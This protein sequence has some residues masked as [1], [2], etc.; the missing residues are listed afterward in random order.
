MSCRGRFGQPKSMRSKPGALGPSE[1]ARLAHPA[2][3]ERRPGVHGPRGTHVNH[4]AWSGAR[5]T[6]LSPRRRSLSTSTSRDDS[7]GLAG[8]CGRCAPKGCAVTTTAVL[9]VFSDRGKEFPDADGHGF[10][11]RNAAD[12]RHG[13][14][15]AP[16]DGLG[17]QQGCVG[18]WAPFRRDG[19]PTY[20]GCGGSNSPFG[21]WTSFN[22]RPFNRATEPLGVGS[23]C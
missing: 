18:R 4:P 8:G 21:L 5:R 17:E 10:R 11:G 7:D 22:V 6:G 19:A 14:R 12:C 20:A 3:G 1:V 2:T 23:D 13:L 16:S 15:R 9:L